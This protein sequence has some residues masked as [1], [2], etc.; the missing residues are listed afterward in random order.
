MYDLLASQQF[1]EEASVMVPVLQVGK[2]RHKEARLLVSHRTRIPARHSRDYLATLAI[3]LMNN[4]HFG[5]LLVFL[6]SFSSGVLSL[7][8]RIRFGDMELGL[9]ILIL[10]GFC[11]FAFR[12][13]GR[14]SRLGVKGRC[15]NTPDFG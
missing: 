7:T 13:Q 3:Q 11:E 6:F 5:A 15:I 14:A 10:F 8:H 2:V 4:R 1:G 9:C 12:C